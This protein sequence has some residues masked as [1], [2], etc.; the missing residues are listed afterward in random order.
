VISQ[1][2]VDVDG[3]LADWV[4]GAVDLFGF[5]EEELYDNWEIGQDITDAAGISLNELWRGID[6][7]GADF[8]AN[9]EP[10]P[11][12][13]D[14][15]DLCKSIAPTIVLTSPSKHPLS[16]AGKIIWLNNQFGAPF[17]D[18]LIGSK[19]EFCARQGSVLIDDNDEK[20]QKFIA[21]GG[22]AIVFPQP[23]NVLRGIED[24]F[25]FVADAL[26]KLEDSE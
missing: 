13:N 6:A 15:W 14:L 7:E 9:L 5:D 10:F 21:N 24:K 1:I 19:K 2:C 22:R 20:C 3:V 12:A 17:R 26:R 4:K 11:W 25:E 18:F 16:L 23:W 8:W